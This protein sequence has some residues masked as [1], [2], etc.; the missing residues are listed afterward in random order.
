MRRKER[1]IFPTHDWLLRINKLGF[2]TRMMSMRKCKEWFYAE[3]LSE[4][5]DEIGDLFRLV[6]ENES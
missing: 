4:P 3:F 5:N 2:G 6:E 1:P